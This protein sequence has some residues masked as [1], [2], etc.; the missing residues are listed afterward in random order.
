M[1]R[2][3]QKLLGVDTTIRYPEDIAKLQAEI[4]ELADLP[5]HVV[6]ALYE[7]WSE[8]FYSASWMCMDESRFVEEF[9]EWL[10]EDV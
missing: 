4:P 1:T 6:Q 2:L 8:Y 9:A 10:R 3:E 5:R 7:D